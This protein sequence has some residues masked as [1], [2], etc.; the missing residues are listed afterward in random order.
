MAGRPFR[1]ARQEKGAGCERG[2]I[3][4]ERSSVVDRAREHQCVLECEKPLD[5][6][7]TCRDGDHCA[8]HGRDA[9]L[10]RASRGGRCDGK[11]SLLRLS[12]RTLFLRG[13]DRAS[14]RGPRRCSPRGVQPLPLGNV[15]LLVPTL[16]KMLF[17]VHENVH[18]D[19]YNGPMIDAT[20]RSL[21]PR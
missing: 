20:R 21:W 10:G 16:I 11:Y 12:G 9:F 17:Y 5:R 7:R 15:N 1:G 4:A 19:S 3:G 2:K 6:H 13:E 18:K 14:D 8:L